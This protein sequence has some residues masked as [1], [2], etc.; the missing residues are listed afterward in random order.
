MEGPNQYPDY[1][2]NNEVLGLSDAQGARL[3]SLDDLKALCVGPDLSRAP[4]PAVLNG[5]LQTVGGVD[6]GGGGVTGKSRT[7]IWV[8]GILPG[9]RLRTLFY[10][11]Y[12]GNNP[13]DDVRDIAEIFGQYSV[14]MVGGDA[15]GGALA[16]SMLRDLLG[17]HRVVQI[18]YGSQ[19]KP[20]KWNDVD[21]Y[22]VDRTTMIDNFLMFL[23]KRKA[24]YGPEI[25]MREAVADVLNVFEEMTTHG[26]KIWQKYPEKT[27]DCLHAQIYGWFAAKMVQSDLRFYESS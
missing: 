27:D 17:A 21:R 18:Q 8:W 7:V 19:P 5:V 12:P 6:W 3:I 26:K 4:V 1:R 11:I 20:A 15:G 25:L 10:K 14:S 16:N 9:G 13:V 22:L 2:F 24:D 23:K